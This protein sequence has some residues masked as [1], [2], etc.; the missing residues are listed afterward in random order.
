M[1]NNQLQYLLSFKNWGT[2]RYKYFPTIADA[3]EFLMYYN[4]K[5]L[6]FKEISLFDTI[7]KKEITI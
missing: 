5:G 4:G 1:F 6:N 7:N 3:K 2:M